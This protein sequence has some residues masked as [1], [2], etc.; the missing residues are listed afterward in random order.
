[1]Y[2]FVTL[3][4]LPHAAGSALGREVPET[5]QT[6]MLKWITGVRT[7]TREPSSMIADILDLNI[8]E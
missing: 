7:C 2:A 4:A 1:M 3:A 5:A 6:E 8:N